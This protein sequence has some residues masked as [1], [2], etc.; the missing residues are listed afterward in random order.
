MTLSIN[1]T[2][3]EPIEIN[4]NDDF[5]TQG[6]PGNGTE[7]SPFRISGL[8]IYSEYTCINISNVDAFFAISNSWLYYDRET[9]PLFNSLSNGIALYNTSNGIIESCRITDK[10]SGISLNNSAN[11]SIN[12]NI[13]ERSNFG[14]YVEGSASCS[15]SNSTFDS[16]VESIYLHNSSRLIFANSHFFNIS[17]GIDA[18]FSSHILIENCQI[19][20]VWRGMRQGISLFY[21]E[22]IVI[23][24]NSIVSSGYGIFLSH[25]TRCLIS[26]NTIYTADFGIEVGRGDSNKITGNRIRECAGNGISI[27]DETNLTFTYNEIIGTDNAGI[28]LRDGSFNWFYGNLIYNNVRNNPERPPVIDNGNDNQWDDGGGI[29]NCWGLAEEDGPHE[30]EGDAGSIDHY[31]INADSIYIDY[32]II[33]SPADVILTGNETEPEILWIAW[34]TP[35]TYELYIDNIL[36]ETGDW[37]ESGPFFKELVNLGFVSHTYTLQICDADGMNSSDTVFVT[38]PITLSF[39][40]QI[41]AACAGGIII[42]GLVVVYWQKKRRIKSYQF[43]SV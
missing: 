28:E 27:F 15:V 37:P 8:S 43:T 6:W 26:Q 38:S 41:A 13:F 25:L 24:N 2:D 19:R 30:I 5:F 17:R 23:T 33:S 42:I 39:M 12:S 11:C 18:Y 40:V 32:P 3:H 16:T 7:A 14:M 35:G 31:P 34:S 9:Y 21:G 4:G 29:G 20:E 1:Y 36:D 22:D 10:S